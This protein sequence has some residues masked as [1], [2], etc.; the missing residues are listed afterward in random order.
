M[1]FLDDISAPKPPAPV[2]PRSLFGALSSFARE[3]ADAY[4]TSTVPTK[5]RPLPNARPSRP[6][7]P[8]G[9]CAC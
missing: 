9:S 6:R 3:V 5:H 4:E 8:R 7:A 1:K 2:A